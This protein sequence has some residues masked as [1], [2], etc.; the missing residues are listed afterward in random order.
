MTRVGPAYDPRMTRIRSPAALTI[1]NPGTMIDAADFSCCLTATVV[2][3]AQLGH[4]SGYFDQNSIPSV[5]N[6][7]MSSWSGT[8]PSAFGCGSRVRSHTRAT[9]RSTIDVSSMLK[10]V[11]A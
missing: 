6:H 10:A 3:Q 11:L 8:L 4:L 7:W 1:P 9:S 5:S 2:Q